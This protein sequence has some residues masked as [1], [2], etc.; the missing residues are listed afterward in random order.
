MR[1]VAIS[2]DAPEVS[3]NLHKKAGYTFTL[4]SDPNTEAIRRYDLLHKGAGEHGH[5]IARPAEFSCRSLRH[6]SL[7]ESDGRL[8][9][10]C[11]TGTD[12]RRREDDPVRGPLLALAL[13]SVGVRPV[14]LWE[15]IHTSTDVSWL[16]QVASM[17]DSAPSLRMNE[18]AK[19]YRSQAYARLGELGTPESL[20]AIDRIESAAKRWRPNDDQ[21][22]LGVLPHPGWHMGDNFVKAEVS[23]RQNGIT[24]AVF[25]DYLFGDMDLLL[26]SKKNDATSWSR[27][28][29]LPL[30]IYR[31]MR[32]LKLEP[33]GRGRLILHFVQDAPPARGIME[34]TH[35]P[36]ESA[37]TLG[38][39][40]VTIDIASA[41][42][43]SDG[44]GLT[45]VEE[46]RLGLSPVNPDSDGDG[47]RDGD[48]T[49]PD[50]APNA[51]HSDETIILQKAFFATF[52]ISGSRYTLFAQPGTVPIQPWG[53]RACVLYRTASKAYGAVSVTWKI[54]ERTESTAVVALTDGEGP[55]AAGGV[56]VTLE[57]KGGSWYVVKVT[58]TW[59]S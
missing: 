48:D 34:G 39:H 18:S 11:A 47:I 35:D 7:G 3:E 12:D 25:V 30:K 40:E 41:L 57:R 1:P 8:A 13:L 16:E 27:P 31:G 22:S 51:D 52:G 26:I 9:R 42:R 45:D 54:V 20:H 43:D 59:V 53:S 37:P 6:G 5:D 17:T 15:Q 29:L 46:K 28:H 50:F 21:F 33:G 19:A 56:N 23:T 36:G 24:Y 14:N 55:L 10:A 2:V 4:L 49:A 58:T 38:P 44:D 32:N